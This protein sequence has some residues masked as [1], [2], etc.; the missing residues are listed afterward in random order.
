MASTSESR[1]MSAAVFAP[2]DPPGTRAAAGRQHF[3]PDMPA[4]LHLSRDPWRHEVVLT[5]AS[6][7]EPHNPA[8]PCT[9]PPAA[10]VA[11]NQESRAVRLA[12]QPRFRASR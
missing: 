7:V 10:K 1:L 3:A 11:A 2:F 8:L 12:Q 6:D 5:L 9:E 4:Y